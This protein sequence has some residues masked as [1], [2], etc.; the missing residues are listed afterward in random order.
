M[1]SKGRVGPLALGTYK[2][3]VDLS[4]FS[5]AADTGKIPT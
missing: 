3:Q 5:K 4:L 1:G 2:V